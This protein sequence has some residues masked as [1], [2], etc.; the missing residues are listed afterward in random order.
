MNLR[1]SPPARGRVGFV[2]R[3]EVTQASAGDRLVWLCGAACEGSYFG[4]DFSQ[5]ADP[6][7]GAC[8]EYVLKKGFE[9]SECC[10][11]TIELPPRQFVIRSSKGR[12]GSV[13]VV[14]GCSS[15]SA[16]AD[17][18][19]ENPAV[20][21]AV[22][23]VEDPVVYWAVEA[24]KGEKAGD[25]CL[26]S[27]PRQSFEDGWRQ[28][29]EIGN[30]VRV[31]T[32]DVHLNAAVAASCAAVEG[33]YRD[34]IYTHAGMSWAQPFLGWR[35]TFGGTAYGWHENVRKQVEICVASQVKEST[36][37]APK[38]DPK[39]GLARQALDSRLF[40]RG[41]VAL[42]HPVHYDMQ[43]QFFDQAHHDWRYTADPEIERL[44]RPALELHLEYISECFD[45]D[46]GF[47]LSGV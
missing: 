41:R 4:T 10:G 46:R 8:R 35:T 26:A 1:L 34:G 13:T 24:F 15:A 33:V 40:G 44:L 7:N 21:G 16:P 19:D 22:A 47:A 25:V 17:K 27:N 18:W 38:A 45:P 37:T 28:A 39:Y 5:N 31:E 14:G 12:G 6:D 11:N 36:F 9:P 20:F 3:V 32:P 2:G 29:E 23:A 30:Q 43:T 42:Y